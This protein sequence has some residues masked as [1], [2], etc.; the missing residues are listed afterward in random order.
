MAPD[1]R[2]MKAFVVSGPDSSMLRELPI[3]TVAGHEVLARVEA[4]GICGSDLE[5]LDGRR[6]DA[7]V[8]SP[9]V[10]GPEWCGTWL[11][12]AKRSPGL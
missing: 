2:R 10:P 11:P 7:Y 5:L 12:S 4:A 9:V 6:P 1:D 8:R 3:P